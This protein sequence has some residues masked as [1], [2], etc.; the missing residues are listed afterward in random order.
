MLLISVIIPVYNSEKTIRATIESVLN[1]TFLDFEL[2]I[3]NDGSQDSTLDIISS[4]QDT[5]IK[6]FSYPN[7]GIS[8]SRN[9]GISHA[10]GE[11]IAFLDHD[12][13]WTPD[14]LELQLKALQENPKAAVAYS[15]VDFIDESNQVI[16]S[17]SRVNVTSAAYAKLLSTNFL[18]TAS[19][20]LI[21]R[22]A[23][24]AIR[25]FDESVFG[26]EDWD[27]FIRLAARYDFVGVLQVQVLFRMSAGSAST[28]VSRMEAATLQVIER[29]FASAPE[30]LQH[31]KKYSLANLYTYL[32]FKSLENPSGRQVSLTAARFLW[33]AVKND[34][35]M[36]QR[37]QTLLKALF[38]IVAVAL[39]PSKQSQILVTTAKNLFRKSNK[40]S[41]NFPPS[42]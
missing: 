33:Q 24:L 4:I 5:R 17:G 26:P 29:G 42:A 25:G 35:S 1:Q 38:K 8:V 28:N 34:R 18:Y 37:R 15:W 30:H 22:N 2:I 20:P 14:K 19:N 10:S 27:L 12:D 11:F 32:T 41:R 31:L 9:R 36:L 21:R 39:L 23:L 3:I 6:V 7:G 40:I 16:R 13:L